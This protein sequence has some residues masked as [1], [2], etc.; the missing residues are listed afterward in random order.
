MKIYQITVIEDGCGCETLVRIFTK[1]DVAQTFYEGL[2]YDTP[3]EYRLVE[4]E[5]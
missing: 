5:V 2:Q 3:N 4:I 1:E